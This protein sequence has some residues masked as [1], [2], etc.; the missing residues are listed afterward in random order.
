MKQK[1]TAVLFAAAF[2]LVAHGAYAAPITFF[3]EDLGLGEDMVLGATPNADAAQLSFLGSLINPG[4]ETFENNS[5]GSPLA[6]SFLNG[7][8]A[9]LSGSGSVVPLN[10]GATNGAGRYGVTNDGGE[11]ER[12]WDAE[13]GVTSFTITFSSAVSAFGF[14]GI[15]I[16]DFNGQLTV[17]TSGGLN[18]V[19]NV[20][21]SQNILGGSVL[22]WGVIDP[23]AT[24]NSVSF[25][26]TGSG[27]DYF[28]F[29]DFT[30]GTLEQVR[31]PVPEPATLT[32]LGMGLAG[33]A[34]R[35]RRRAARR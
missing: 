1:S 19:F 26:N 29:D 3:G 24:F 17:T 35:H 2:G 25:S 22:F 14:F 21:N 34:A 20:N 15:D 4:I 18:Q 5:G 13:G 23:S 27:T 8:T 30:I 28:A 7:V 31:T 10:N 11:D 16:G 32:L 9:T 12:Y 33:L 6:V